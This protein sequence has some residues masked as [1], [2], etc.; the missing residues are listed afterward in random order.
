MPYNFVTFSHLQ[1]VASGRGSVD[2]AIG[3]AG[4]H[5]GW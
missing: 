2:E 3:H 4:E 5:G 1:E